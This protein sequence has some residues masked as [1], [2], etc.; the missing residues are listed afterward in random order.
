[1]G[2]VRR[3]GGGTRQLPRVPWRASLQ[4]PRADAAACST[5]EQQAGRAQPLRTVQQLERRCNLA[6]ERR[7]RRVARVK[8][9]ARA[10]E[11][12]HARLATQLLHGKALEAGH[13]LAVGTPLRKQALKNLWRGGEEFMRGM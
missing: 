8:A 11:A 1:M 4:L 13:D 9:L 3:C 6:H 10:E 12:Q 5:S 7:R 2:A